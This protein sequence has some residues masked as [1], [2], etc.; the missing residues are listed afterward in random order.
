MKKWYFLTVRWAAVVAACFFCAG[1]L[2][3]QTVTIKYTTPGTYSA[4]IPAGVTAATGEA[5]G[6]GGGG[7]GAQ[8]SYNSSYG[9]VSSGG[10][11]GGGYILCNNLTGNILIVV[12]GGG[13][14]GTGTTNGINGGDS[15]IDNCIATGG[16]GGTF[17]E[18]SSSGT[19]SAGKGGKGGTG[20]STAN[21]GTDGGE[22]GMY[23]IPPPGVGG[24]G[25]NN[26]A[27]GGDGVAVDNYTQGTK[28]GGN[29]ANGQV[30]LTLTL[31]TPAIAETGPIA[32][33]GSTTLNVSSPAAGLKCGWYK[34]GTYMGSTKDG[35]SL[36]VT[37]S[38]SYTVAYFVD[39]GDFENA[40][41]SGPGAQ[42]AAVTVTMGGGGLSLDQPANGS[43]C[44]GS[45]L[46]FPEAELNA[47]AGTTYS[48]AVSNYNGLSGGASSGTGLP[49]ET[50]GNA[51]TSPLTVT[52]AITAT[53][54]GCS[55]T[56]NWVLTVNPVPAIS[57]LA[58]TCFNT[59]QTY[60]ADIAGGSWSSSNLS[61]GSINP[62]GV[63]RPHESVTEGAT[64]NTTISYAVNGCVSNGIALTVPPT[65]FVMSGGLTRIYCMDGDAT[66]KKLEDTISGL[67]YY[68]GISIA[69]YSDAAASTSTSAPEIQTNAVMSTATVYF[70]VDDGTCKSQTVQFEYGVN[71]DLG[72]PNIDDRH[73]VYGTSNYYFPKIEGLE[74]YTDAGAT[75]GTD[76]ATIRTDV[77]GISS[78][79]GTLTRY[80]KI[81]LTTGCES[82]V[83]EVK[84]HVHAVPAITL[85]SNKSI[86]CPN[87]GNNSNY[88]ATLTYEISNPDGAISSY[89]VTLTGPGGYSQNDELTGSPWKG[90]KVV[91][92][93]GTYTITVYQMMHGTEAVAAN[94][95]DAVTITAYQDPHV[96][97]TPASVQAVCYGEP[98]TLPLPVRTLGNNPSSTDE[99]KLGAAT[100]TAGTPVTDAD[101]QKALAYEVTTSCGTFAHQAG[102]L[103]VR[104]EVDFVSLN[105]I[106]CTDGHPVLTLK[107]ELLLTLEYTVNGQNP[108]VYGLPTQ[109]GVA[110]GGYAVSGVGTNT[111]TAALPSLPVG[112]YT[113]HFT[114]ITD[115]NGCS[116]VL[117][118]T[119][120]HTAEARIR[121]EYLS[122]VTIPYGS[123]YTWTNTDGQNLT[124]NYPGTYCYT[125]SFPSSTGCDSVQVL[126]LRMTY[127]GKEI[128]GYGIDGDG[129]LLTGV[130]ID[131]TCWLD[132][133]MYTTTDALGN[134]VESRVYTAPLYPNEA[135]NLATFG[136]LYDW[137]TAQVICPVGWS[138]PTAA[139]FA[140]VLNQY[141]SAALKT[142]KTGYNFWMGETVNNATKLS[143]VPAGY[144]N[145]SL[146][147]YMYL[148]GD[149]YFWTT[150]EVHTTV[151]KACHFYYGCPAADMIS[152]DKGMGYSVRC[153]QTMIDCTK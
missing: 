142:A 136:R 35:N 66:L 44:S 64:L 118:Q 7:G 86:I 88:Q 124:L 25:V 76:T 22:A 68:H 79:G 89:R 67:S 146:N 60:T 119:V 82:H 72:T 38:G 36:T 149:A 102:M 128:C 12:G 95:I 94:S 152:Q 106:S 75:T 141:G 90:S 21:D 116:K 30:V 9:R 104:P 117:S 132:T 133:N 143:I 59:Q 110:A 26:G 100:Y 39:P 52:Y 98:V 51:T 17:G 28:T 139:Q 3:A 140:N 16:E 108:S 5:W 112:T 126:T 87:N 115:N 83:K 2:H 42:S 47:T 80:A 32:A 40:E 29:G 8:K 135:D 49:S 122:D 1:V 73:L 111:W 151:S 34:D 81:K 92:A 109:F 33:C 97:L 147:Q 145:S 148:L 114:K 127:N 19:I 48:W 62:S 123:T 4:D 63:F 45:A 55:E 153:V 14:G 13:Q 41:I 129:N 121:Y 10:G 23:I 85:A 11:G 101:H 91:D 46:P 69:W 37:E 53:H 24:K 96:T 84:F 125:Y 65:P 56:F 58:S 70:V 6:G 99:W 131:G 61:A 93:A 20:R 150:D 144:Y 31:P 78:S 137:N 138:L 113:F 74:W 15:K 120:T 18:V 134:P 105:L 130:D 103:T 57:G 27:N 71:N 107:G 77:A 43:T 54:G 50:L